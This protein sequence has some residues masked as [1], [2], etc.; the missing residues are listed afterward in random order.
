MGK[1]AFVTNRQALMDV[2]IKTIA[3]AVPENIKVTAR[4]VLQTL[5]GLPMTRVDVESWPR[6]MGFI[7]GVSV[8][9]CVVPYPDPTPR[10]GSN[11]NI[12]INLLDAVR[13][14]P[15]ALAECG[16][17]RG[18]TLIALALHLRQKGPDRMVYGF[19][20]FE[21]FG[22]TI[23]GDLD[24]ERSE[25][26]PQMRASGF[27]DT[28]YKLVADKAR[29]FGLSGVRLVAGYFETSLRTCTE[30]RFAF[31]HLDGD[32]YGAYKTCLEYFYPRLST[33]AIVV[34]DEYNDPPWPG[35]KQAVDE[36]LQ[37]RPEKIEEI[38]RD[39]FVKAFFVKR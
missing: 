31:V 39:N 3:A 9:R 7:H 1:A 4:S 8:P 30:D 20:S 36:F 6:I 10:C 27:S 13:T 21:G 12:L 5:T 34:F 17:Y 22:D 23:L 18:H 37:G 15:G 24:L 28:S 25:V 33:G 26:D 19:D 29:R 14:V 35:C 32:T 2:R 16:V 11:I 38:T